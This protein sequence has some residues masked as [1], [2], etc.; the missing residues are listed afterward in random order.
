MSTS[1]GTVCLERV[2][3]NKIFKTKISFMNATEYFHLWRESHPKLYREVI[4]SKYVRSFKNQ[5]NYNEIL[6]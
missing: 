3:R 5:V 1:S 6:M 4:A 2:R